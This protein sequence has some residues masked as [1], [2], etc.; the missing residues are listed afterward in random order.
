MMTDWLPEKLKNKLL[1]LPALLEPADAPVWYFIL[2]FSAAVLTGLLLFGLAGFIY[3]E[4]AGP[5]EL[6]YRL[7]LLALPLLAA[8]LLCQAGQWGAYFT[9]GLAL[10]ASLYW[11]NK[12]RRKVQLPLLLWAALAG[13]GL[14]LGFL[15]PVLFISGLAY[16]FVF[17]LYHYRWHKASFVLLVRLEK[18]ALF[19]VEE[20]LAALQQRQSG[21]YYLAGLWELVYQVSLSQVSQELLDDLSGLAGVRQAV[22]ISRAR[23]R[24]WPD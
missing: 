21:R 20:K 18:A 17:L 2:L 12:V 13:A 19:A 7:S 9:F 3:R 24:H 8:I 23:G 5:Q 22:V 1:Y 16:L 14:A 6:A 10:L 15:V 11:Q 4:L